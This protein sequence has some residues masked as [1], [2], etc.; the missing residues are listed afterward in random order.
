MKAEEIAAAVRAIEEGKQDLA[1]RIARIIKEY[2]D[3]TGCI[4]NQVNVRWWHRHGA[5]SMPTV[6]LEVQLSRM[7]GSPVL[8][9][10][11]D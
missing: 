9:S 8:A 2:H 7:T 10:E 5:S 6:S 4:V 1:E 11:D 3:S